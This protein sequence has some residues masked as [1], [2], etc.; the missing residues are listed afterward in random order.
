MI[1]DHGI[2]KVRASGV[3]KG[4]GPSGLVAYLIDDARWK[5]RI[6]FCIL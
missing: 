6:M 3:L 4:L 1:I 2:T 5:I